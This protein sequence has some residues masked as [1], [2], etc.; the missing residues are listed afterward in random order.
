MVDELEHTVGI[1]DA[2][3]YRPKLDFMAL[4][5]SWQLRTILV[6]FSLPDRFGSD[7][8]TRRLTTELIAPL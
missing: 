6:D 1:G 7:S 8:S 3:F 4:E 5:R 2:A